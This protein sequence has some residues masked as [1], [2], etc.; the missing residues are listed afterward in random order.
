MN[1]VL[2]QHSVLKLPKEMVDAANTD[3]EST[4]TILASIIEISRKLKT[5]EPVE[6][7]EVI[8]EETATRSTSNTS[9]PE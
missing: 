2:N 7:T 4:A 5:G 3:D 6:M 1:E 8:V 9:T